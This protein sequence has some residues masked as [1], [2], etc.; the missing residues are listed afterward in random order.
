MPSRLWL[1]PAVA[2]DVAMY[3]V[4]IRFILFAWGKTPM[5]LLWL[6]VASLVVVARYAYW[7]DCFLAGPR[8][9]LF[10]W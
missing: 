6:L 7:F 9:L 10:I 8:G 1:L 4:S 2:A 5:P 3:A